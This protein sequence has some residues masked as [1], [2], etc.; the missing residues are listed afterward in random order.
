MAA[1]YRN[2]PV[3]YSAL[4]Q[5]WGVSTA[6]FWGD[7]KSSVPGDLVQ[8]SLRLLPGS[9]SHHNGGEHKERKCLQEVIS[10]PQLAWDD[11][12]TRGV[13]LSGIAQSGDWESRFSAEAWLQIQHRSN[14]KPQ[15]ALSTVQC[16]CNHVPQCSAA[17]MSSTCMHVPFPEKCGYKI[18][19]SLLAYVFSRGDSCSEQNS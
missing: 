15:P 6:S 9:L 10:A 5:K 17:W 18:S 3:V 12:S 14:F 13:P 7:A 1:A 19:P 4:P 11:S 2:S 8:I 16:S